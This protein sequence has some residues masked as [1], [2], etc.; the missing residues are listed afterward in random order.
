LTILKSPVR[1]KPAN[2][3]ICFLGQTLL[4]F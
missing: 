4:N 3:S 1:R 2:K